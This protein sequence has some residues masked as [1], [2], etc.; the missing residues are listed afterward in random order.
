M[1]SVLMMCECIRRE[2]MQQFLRWVCHPYIR[3]LLTT[4]TGILNCIRA[5]GGYTSAVS[6]ETIFDTDNFKED[7]Y[8]AH[9]ETKSGNP[10]LALNWFV[11]EY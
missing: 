4:G 8:L 9:I 6:A 3:M 11:L 10:R 7:E 5:L 2:A 1:Y